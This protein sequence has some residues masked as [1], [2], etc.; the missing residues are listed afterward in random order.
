MIVINHSIRAMLSALHNPSFTTK[1]KE[2]PR[3]KKISSTSNELPETFTPTVP[4]LA[5]EI[6]SIKSL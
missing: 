2:V 4:N 6:K 1:L 5:K 3:V